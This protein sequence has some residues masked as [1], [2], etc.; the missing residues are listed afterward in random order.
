MRNPKSTFVLVALAVCFALR[1]GAQELKY[2]RPARFFEEALPIGNG[3]IGAMVYGGTH[4]FRMSLNDITLW[5]GEPE[6]ESVNPE[7][8]KQ[9]PAVR[10]ALER[11]DYAAA[12]TLVMRMQGHESEKYQPLGTLYVD[13]LSN[14]STYTSYSRGLSLSTASATSSYTVAGGD[15]IET[16]C[17]ASSPDSVMVARFVSSSGAGISARVRLACQLPHETEASGSRLV[18]RGYAAYTTNSYFVTGMHGE[19][20]LYNHDRGIHFMTIVAAEN[21]GGSVRTDGQTLL[22]EGCGELVLYIVNSTS[23]AGAGMDP[24]EE[25]LDYAAEAERNIRNALDRGLDRIRERQIADYQGLYNRVSLYLGETAP[26]IKALPTDVQLRLYTKKKQRNPELEALYFQYGRYLLISSSRTPGVPAN[27]QGLWNERLSPPWRSNYTTNI[28]LEE[29]YWGAETANLSE[30][31]LPL[32]GFIDAMVP[33]GRVSAETFYGVREGWCAGHNSDIWAM[34]NPVGEG[35]ANPQWANWTM[36]GAWLSTHIWEH[37]LFSRDEEALRAHYPALRGA[38]EFCMNWLVE[39]DGELITSFSTSPENMY[40]TSRG[41]K[42]NT[43]YGGTA[44]LA[45]I[46]ECVTDAALAAGVLGTDSAFRV[47]AGETLSRLRPYR[48]GH[49]G[50]LLEWYH[51]WKDADWTHRHQSHLIGL[52]PGHQI[53]PSLTPD[54]ASASARTLKIKGNRTT[55]WSTGWRINLYAR[56]ADSKQAYSMVRTLLRYISPD[57]YKG[58]DRV[59][60]GGTYPNLLDAHS[61]FQIDGNFGGSA[62]IAEMLVQSTEDTITMLPACPAEWSAGS[63]AGLCARGGAVLVF[64]WS[65]G[66]VTSLTVTARAGIETTITANGREYPV[67]LVA[68]ESARV[69]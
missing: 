51:D 6:R 56:L 16:E 46:R 30:L 9:L 4:S 67:K 48:T 44:D 13:F 29:N 23:F 5:T 39:K 49:R 8:Y 11:E 21:R 47:S 33:S 32:L 34:T 27:L 2:D 35:V 45:I 38:A 64:S 22:A 37:W 60:G 58:R 1:A 41:Y 15:R 68:G 63:A 52:Y 42:G 24:A 7:A 54:L 17:F 25:G 3:R 53:T 26:E 55:G 69:I 57:E 62:G 50:Q 28:N 66:M 19:H 14:D 10:E 59:G 43:F 18:N 36:G 12:D 20:G 40:V 65:G 61:P 31:H